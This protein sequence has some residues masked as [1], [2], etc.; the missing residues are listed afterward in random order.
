MIHPGG[1][2]GIPLDGHRSRAA[3]NASWT[4]SSAMSMS[5][6][7]RISEATALPYSRRK[8]C[9]TS[10]NLF[11][12]ERADFDGQRGRL[13][14]SPSPFERGI[15]IRRPDDGEPAEMFL[16][17]DVRAVS[18]EDISFSHTDDCGTAGWMEPA[19]KHPG[20]RGDHAVSD[21]RDVLH[22]PVE[23]VGRRRRAIRLID[24]EQVLSHVSS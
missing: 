20:V 14:Q 6:K 21:D 5:P 2:G 3:V 23:D 11:V 17:L 4:D 13:C 24:A 19:R 15:Q 18:H 8:I 10:L 16:A 7:T 22:D 9:S 12:L 1:L